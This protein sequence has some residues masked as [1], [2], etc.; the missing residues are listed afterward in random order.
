MAPQ[1]TERYRCQTCGHELG[2]WLG[3]CPSCGEWGTLQ[4][5]T[6]PASKPKAQT[7]NLTT[8]RD[9]TPSEPTAIWQTLHSQ[10][11]STQPT[12]R[13]L[14]LGEPGIEEVLGGG[15]VP[16]ALVLM[17]GTPGVGKSTLWL[18]CATRQTQTHFFYV[19]GEESIDQ[20]QIRMQ[21]LGTFPPTL[22]ITELREVHTL[23]ESLN[24][25]LKTITGP[26]IL[27]VDSL[28]TVWDESLEAPPGSIIQL[29]TCSALFQQF[30]KTHHIPII[31]IGHVTKAGTVAGPMEIAHLVD[32]VLLFEGDLRHPYRILR[33]LKNRFGPTGTI[34]LYEMTRH[35]LRLLAAEDLL[36][37]R[38]H[39]PPGV[40]HSIVQEG[41]RM[42]LVEVQAL[43]TRSYYATPQRSLIG[44]DPRRLPVLL[45]ILE[46]HGR[47]FFGQRDVFVQITGGMRITDASLDMAI[48]VALATSYMDLA[49]P[50][51]W[52]FTGEAGLTGEL[53]PP[54]SI[55]ARIRYLQRWGYHLVTG[56]TPATHPDQ[57]LT[58]LKNIRHL[59]AWLQKQGTAHSPPPLE[60]R[61]D[62]SKQNSRQQH[63]QTHGA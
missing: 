31:L 16:G 34:A 13:R 46:K 9:L 5:I 1:P 43:V 33:S 44:Y 22:H 45:A 63:Q 25:Y 58:T 6:T 38:E 12:T 21:R 59:L 14:P 36:P 7:R 42:L 23:L 3:K 30:A 49:L 20:L 19:A 48:L 41:N 56:A 62:T 28:Q 60:K 39:F 26:A 54:S 15:L 55:E 29:R 35:G 52:A 32:V 27:I 37:A 61:E 4:R 57:T 2:R 24:N 50:G 40:A 47:L 10:S 8:A 51:K 11:T 18:Q 53:L 17:G